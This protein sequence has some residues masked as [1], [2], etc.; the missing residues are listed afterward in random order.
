MVE[1]ERSRDFAVLCSTEV[2]CCVLNQ[3]ALVSAWIGLFTGR[4]LIEPQ[5][6]ENG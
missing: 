4:G 2:A 3:V 1:V 5:A 6:W